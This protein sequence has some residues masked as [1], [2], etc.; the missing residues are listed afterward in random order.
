MYVYEPLRHSL[1]NKEI[2]FPV[3]PL[4]YRDGVKGIKVNL[5]SGLQNTELTDKENVIIIQTDLLFH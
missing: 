2:I 5:C 1:G 3:W 4:F